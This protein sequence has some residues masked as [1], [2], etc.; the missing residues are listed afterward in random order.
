MLVR[1]IAPFASVAVT[2]VGMQRP[3][4]ASDPWFL[5]AR[6]GGC[7]PISTLERKL[8]DLPAVRDPQGFA[9]YVQG[10]GWAFTQKPHALGAG[11]AVEF[12]VPSQG[13]ALMFVTRDLCIAGQGPGR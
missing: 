4:F 5:A 3:A 6:E 13:L 9:D 8:P 1:L 11:R 7:F 12:T 2:F 10:K